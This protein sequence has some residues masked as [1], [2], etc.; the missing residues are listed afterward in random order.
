M[1]VHKHKNGTW[2][3]SV[4]ID[5]KQYMRQSQ[6]WTLKRHAVQAE[7]DFLA[8]FY[9]D[10][11][12]DTNILFKEVSKQYIKYLSLH[13]KFSTVKKIKNEIIKHIDTFFG[14]MRI[15]NITSKDIENF[16]K[17]LLETTYTYMDEE[18]YF[19]NTHL[20][21]IQGRARLVFDYAVRHRLLTFNPFDQVEIAK[22]DEIQ[23]TAEYNILTKDEFDRFMAVIDDQT[24]RT[25]YSILYWCGLRIGEAL[26]LNIEDYDPLKATIHVYKSYDLKNRSLSTTKTGN[27]R[28]VDVPSACKSELDKLLD[29]YQEKTIKPHLALLG[30]E[31]RLVGTTIDR[32]KKYYIEQAGLDY[33]TNHDLRHTHV[34]TLIQLGA[35]PIDISKRLGHSV[36]M[37]NNTYGHLFESDKQ[38]ILNKLNDL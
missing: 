24:D 6:E 5:G 12:K 7:Q 29:I 4:R 9:S 35:R 32:Y 31:K 30:L 21:N 25:L 33:F 11:L 2:Y 37:V 13:R 38:N 15:K 16:Q 23:K 26:A 1:S 19:S 10:N 22:R 27:S 8:N 14:E 36:E 3:F 20:T 34:S 28:I 17:Q 18:R